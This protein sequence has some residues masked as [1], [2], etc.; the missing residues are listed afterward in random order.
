MIILVKSKFESGDSR[1]VLLEVILCTVVTLTVRRHS[2]LVSQL[3]NKARQSSK[4]IIFI[5][6]EKNQKYKINHVR[7][8][9]YID[10]ERREVVG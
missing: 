3:E 9:G 7:S 5:Q 10:W 1:D 4:K 2:S 6:I 8:I